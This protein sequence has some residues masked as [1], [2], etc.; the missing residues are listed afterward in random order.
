[1]VCLRVS[2]WEQEGYSAVI[3]LIR[4][5]LT[6]CLNALRHLSRRN[7]LMFSNIK[8]SKSGKILL[9]I[10]LLSGILLLVGCASAPV[11]G[12]SG[13]VVS[14]NTL[15]VGTIKGTVLALDIT[16]NGTSCTFKWEMDLGKTASGGFLTC[17]RQVSVAMSTYGTPAVSGDKIY[18]GGYDGNVYSFSK[19]DGSRLFFETGSAIIGSP[20]IANDTV[21][22][23]TS[24]GKLYAFDLNLKPK[25]AAPFK[26]GGKIWSM[27]EV[28]N[29][30]VY[31]G[32]A[33]HRLYAIDAESGREIW[34]FEAEAGILSTP[35]I[36]NGTVYIGAC[37]NK[38]YAIEVATEGEKLAASAREDRDPIPSK[39]YKGVFEGANS[40]FWTQALAY[41]GKIYVGNLDHKLYVLDAN[42]ISH[43]LDEFETGGRIC[44]PPVLVG[45]S[46][47]IGSEDGNIYILNPENLNDKDSKKVI[48]L[49][50]SETV[51][52][53][54]LAPLYPDYEKGIVYVHAQDGVHRLYAI[55]VAD[56]HQLWTYETS[57]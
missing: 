49:K 48:D 38:F 10:L 16:E 47:I 35:L 41:D 56:G 45:G 54:I 43:K 9:C 52:A 29:G 7:G 26:T 6:L 22:V 31:V 32:S 25:W 28:A 3:P 13:S 20:V 34:H 17:S 23:G 40:W 2:G 30:V 14:D 42:D 1:M 44:T 21:F 33:D 50:T 39:E 51:K 12:W 46:I 19:D 36:Y 53:P 8:K 27:P 11:R 24:D 5:V 57:G 4:E 18:I 37:D 55:R 15:Y